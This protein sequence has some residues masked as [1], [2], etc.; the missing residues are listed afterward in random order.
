MLVSNISLFSFSCV[1][2]A[3]TNASVVVFMLPAFLLFLLRCAPEV[4]LDG[5]FYVQSDV[6]A[7]AVT[8]WEV[9][10]E[11]KGTLSLTRT[12]LSLGSFRSHVICMLLRSKLRLLYLSSTSFFSLIL[13]FRSALGSP[14]K[15][16]GVPRSAEGGATSET[17]GSTRDLVCAHA[18]VNQRRDRERA[19]HERQTERETE[20]G[21]EKEQD[22]REREREN[23]RE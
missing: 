9:F 18:K 13:L 19:G 6:F 2:V 10:A 11:G 22:A 12:W 17:R 5:E 1:P 15:R 4:L 21:R 7:F 3:C 20:G 14:L 16:R 8:M 23:V